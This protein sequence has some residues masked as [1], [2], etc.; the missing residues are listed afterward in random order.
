MCDKLADMSPKETLAA[1]IQR[2][3]AGRSQ[4]WLAE[5]AGVAQ[6]TISRL[7]RARHEPDPRTITRIAH[8]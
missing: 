5:R 2:L 8:V 3:L 6:S 1:E 4:Q 7:M